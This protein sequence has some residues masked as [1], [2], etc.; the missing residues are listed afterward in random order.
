MNEFKIKE[1][2]RKCIYSGKRRIGISCLSIK[3]TQGAKNSRNKFKISKAPG[4]PFKIL[5]NLQQN[6]I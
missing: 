6:F 5:E 1:K 2:E 3:N 4:L